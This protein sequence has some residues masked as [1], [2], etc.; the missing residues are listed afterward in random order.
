M[1]N[2]VHPQT[3]S[4]NPGLR[5]RSFELLKIAHYSSGF[6]IAQA[7]RPKKEKS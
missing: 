6:K 1:L 4:F 2:S 7:F 5:F 3:A